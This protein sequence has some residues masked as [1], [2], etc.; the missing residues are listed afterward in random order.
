MLTKPECVKSKWRLV[1]I[2]LQQGTDGPEVQLEFS[3]LCHILA[4]GE[5]FSTRWWGVK[6][7]QKKER[8]LSVDVCNT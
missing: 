6:M 3:P 5:S 4:I 1:E 8:K 7:G 2:S